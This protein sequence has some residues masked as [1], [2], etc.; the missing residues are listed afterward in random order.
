MNSSWQKK[1]DIISYIPDLLHKKMLPR[2]IPREFFM[3]QYFPL[4]Q[5]LQ[6]EAECLSRLL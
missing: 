3:Q 4:Y 2:K 6:P 1:E 5:S